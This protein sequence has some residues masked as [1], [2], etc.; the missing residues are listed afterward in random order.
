MTQ[1]NLVDPPKLRDGTAPCI[2][3]F[4]YVEDDKTRDSD[5]NGSKRFPNV[6]ADI[7]T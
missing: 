2:S 6:T 7:V 5:L 1:Y 4:F 3:V